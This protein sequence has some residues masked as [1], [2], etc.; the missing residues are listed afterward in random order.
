MAVHHLASDPVQWG[1]VATWVAGIGFSLAF[2]MLFALL[3]IR[4]QEMRAETLARRA[5][6]PDSLEGKIDRLTSSM[7]ESRHLFEQVAAEL[8]ARAAATKLLKEEAESAAALA[9]LNNDQAEAVRRL[10]RAEM[11]T[12]FATS[13]RRI[14]RDSLRIAMVFF[15]A[16]GLVSF[17]LT[18]WHPI[19]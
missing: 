19:G 11:T 16:G 9:A 10:L 8:D 2:F 13:R 3:T 14:S 5:I 15:A 17:L 12:E 18:W 6:S 4:Q 1:N 7:L